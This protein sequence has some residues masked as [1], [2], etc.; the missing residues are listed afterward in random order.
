MMTRELCT[1]TVLCNGDALRH[2]VPNIMI[3]HVLCDL[4]IR[5]SYDSLWYVP[6]EMKNNRI[7]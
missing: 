7:M 3:I 1:I 2:H 6:N 4:V 5:M